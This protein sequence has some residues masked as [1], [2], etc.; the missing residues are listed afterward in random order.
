MRDIGGKSVGK[1]IG[2]AANLQGVN[3]VLQQAAAGFHSDR[4]AFEM[5]RNVCGDFGVFIDSTEVSMN[6]GASERVMLHVLQ[7]SQRIAQAFDIKVDENVL[8]AA[9]GKK[10]FE[11]TGFDLEVFV[12]LAQSVH[13]RRDPAFFAHL[14]ESSGTSLGAEGGFKICFLGHGR[15]AGGGYGREDNPSRG[16][17]YLANRRGFVKI[18]FPDERNF[19]CFIIFP[20]HCSIFCSFCGPGL[21]GSE[22]GFFRGFWLR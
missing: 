1:V 20:S 15:Q 8:R 12:C 19:L 11:T 18:L 3:G 7:E 13:D 14:V 10:I 22:G 21:L 6:R 5:K 4:F 16:A 9:V 17:A 2:H